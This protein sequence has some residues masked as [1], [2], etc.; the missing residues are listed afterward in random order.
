MHAGSIAVRVRVIPERRGGLVDLPAGG[1]ARTRLDH[2]V[3]TPGG[4]GR[5]VHPVPVH[6]CRLVEPVLEVDR[7]LLA[8]RGPQRRSEVGAVEPQV[9]VFSPG[10]S[11]LSPDS[12]IS[13]NTRRPSASIFESASGGIATRLS[14]RT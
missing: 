6:G 10:R 7:H 5:Q 2:L 1:P 12:A 3:R 8:A 9:S 13:A 11:S 14:K 4:V